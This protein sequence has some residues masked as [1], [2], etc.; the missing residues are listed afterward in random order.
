MLSW[1]AHHPIADQWSAMVLW[2]ELAERTRRAANRAPRLTPQRI[3]QPTTLPDGAAVA[4]RRR[5]A[6]E[7]DYWRARGWPA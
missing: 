7:R 2:R 4:S 3:D 1:V 6:R 5:P